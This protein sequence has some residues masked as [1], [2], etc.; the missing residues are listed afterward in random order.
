M[1]LSQHIGREIVHKIEN[2]TLTV[3]SL[4]A[5]QCI[6][7]HFIEELLNCSLYTPLFQGFKVCLR[8][9]GYR[10]QQW[11]EGT[12]SIQTL[13]INRTTLVGIVD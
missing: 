11:K 9:I 13:I 10:D 8:P 6:L 1:N 7:I 4:P 5:I 12:L 3:R 2:L